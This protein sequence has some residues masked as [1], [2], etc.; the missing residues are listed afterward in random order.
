MPI[1]SLI[2]GF[3]PPG[4][5][6]CTIEELEDRFGRFQ[7][8][9]VRCKLLVR[10]KAF[11]A[12]SNACEFTSAVIVDGSFTTDKDEP[13]DIDVLFIVKQSHDL[14]APL[15]PY[16]YNVV[17]RRQVRKLYGFDLL[18]AQEGTP[19]VA[20]YIAFFA[21]IRGDAVRRKGMLKVAP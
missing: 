11:L 19:Q 5:H 14:R 8:R 21:Q 4:V 12:A 16:E 1:P 15:Q 6:D 20:E 10:L 3:L 17:S 7:T 18:V 9:D 13:N 2:D